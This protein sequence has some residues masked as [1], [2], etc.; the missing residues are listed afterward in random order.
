MIGDRDGLQLAIDLV[1]YDAHGRLYAVLDTKY[2]LA[3]KPAARDV[4]QIISYATIKN[5]PQAILIYPAQQ[6]APLDVRLPNLRLRSIS[7]PLDLPL[8]N[9][10]ERFLTSLF[11]E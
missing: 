4:N 2:K 1:L 3:E 6:A 11:A 5:A 10:G 8:A 7:F 9:A